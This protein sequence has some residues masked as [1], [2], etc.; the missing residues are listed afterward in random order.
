M[1]LSLREEI[2]RRIPMPMPTTAPPEKPH[3]I[4]HRL[5]PKC[6]MIRP[7]RINSHPVIRTLEGAGRNRGETIPDLDMISQMQRTTTRELRLKRG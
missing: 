5:A 1:I 7:V 4:L 2:P 6:S 3:Q